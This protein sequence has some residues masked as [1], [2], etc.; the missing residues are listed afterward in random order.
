MCSIIGCRWGFEVSSLLVRGLEKME[1]RGYDSVGTAV[2]SNN[3][4]LV[5]KGVGKVEEVNQAIQ[6]DKL[7]G[8]IGIGH[9]RWATHGGVNEINAHPHLSQSKRVAVVH[10]GILENFAELKKDIKAEFQSETDTEV[11]AAL[12]GEAYDKTCDARK[13]MLQVLPLLE[14]QFAFIALFDDGT[15]AGARNHLPLI[16]GT[17]GVGYF[18]ASDVLGFI[19]WTDEA[20]YIGNKQFI[21]IEPPGRGGVKICSFTGRSVRHKVVKLSKEMA[22]TNKGEYAHFTLK[23]IYEQPKTLL[24]AGKYSQEDMRSAV[25]I[26]KNSKHV[27]TVGSGTS[28]NAALLAKH[29]ISNAGIR[30]E[31]VISSES[32]FCC[33]FDKES[34]L[35]AFSQSGESADILDTADQA[36]KAQS[37]I[38]SIVNSMNSSLARLSSVCIGLNCGPE[39][40]VAATKSFTSQLMVINQLADGLGYMLPSD[41]TKWGSEA[42]ESALNRSFAIKEIAHE[43]RQVTDIYVLGRGPYYPIASEAALKIK[44]ITYIHAEGIPGGELKHGPLALMDEYTYVIAI[45]PTGNTHAAMLDNVRQI[46]ARNS[47]VIGVSDEEN[48]LYDH[49]I[50]VPE[51]IPCIYPIATVIP[52]QLLAYY[53]ALEKDTN[54]DYPRNLAKAV[55]VR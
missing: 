43:L 50:R 52:I 29:W 16:L 5:K 27:Y 22:D 48:S 55:T 28:Y 23:E 24:N 32:S 45:N 36:T 53:L 54:P 49:W 21:I 8:K 47:R 3:Q 44:E 15:I 12:L 18:L 34:V 31:A 2:L 39:V 17:A 6:L 14:G 4:I 19:Q 25:D 35:L 37:T 41:M 42:A 40:G 1:Y 30:A 33:T 20:I 38:I 26:I 7:P 10:N 11:I 46:K 9:T 51:T 13:T